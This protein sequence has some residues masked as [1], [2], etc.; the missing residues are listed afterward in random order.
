MW[1][2]A[3]IAVLFVAACAPEFSP[4]SFVDKPRILGIVANPPEVPFT[5]ENP[6]S[7][8]L[9]VVVAMPGPDETGNLQQTALKD[10]EWA[11]CPMSLGAE[12]TLPVLCLKYLFWT[13]IL[14]L[15]LPPLTAKSCLR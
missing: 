10:L 4:S 15:E 7:V 14:R 8:T 2:I 6:G 12:A 3:L 5:Q 11:V 1:R 13:L 9:H